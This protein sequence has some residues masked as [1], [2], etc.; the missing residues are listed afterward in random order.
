MG[1]GVFP[2]CKKPNKKAISVNAMDPD[3]QLHNVPA[4]ILVA[5][6][7]GE[8]WAV[9]QILFEAIALGGD[10]VRVT[11]LSSRLKRGCSFRAKKINKPSLGTSG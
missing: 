3:D 10:V 5:N 11:L 9:N 4:E 6:V 7:V 2:L 1:S 8:R